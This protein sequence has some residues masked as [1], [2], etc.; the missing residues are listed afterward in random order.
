MFY[1]QHSHLKAVGQKMSTL[2]KVD[3]YIQRNLEELWQ[4]EEL[5][6]QHEYRLCVQDEEIEK[7]LK[8]RFV[9]KLMKQA[10]LIIHTKY[11]R[12]RKK[13]IETLRQFQG[14]NNLEWKKQQVDAKLESD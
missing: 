12:I 7:I 2:K 8:E 4:A 10:E 3:Q 13:Q 9:Q 5:L 11:Q 1:A 6:N 14:T